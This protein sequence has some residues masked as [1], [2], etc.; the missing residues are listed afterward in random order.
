[1]RNKPKMTRL[2]LD[3]R[4]KGRVIE[5]FSTNSF[6]Y[7]MHSFNEWGIKA[8][9]GYGYSHSFSGILRDAEAR[10]QIRIDSESMG[11]TTQDEMCASYS[12]RPEAHEY[13][14]KTTRE[15]CGFCRMEIL[16]AGINQDRNFRTVLRGLNGAEQVI[17][18]FQ[19]GK[20][21]LRR[22]TSEAALKLLLQAS[23]LEY[24]YLRGFY[25]PSGGVT[26]Q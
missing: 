24:T 16:P 8:W 19:W 9:G 23:D 20:R 13:Y 3:P 15:T 22:N 1:M 4:Y 25:L 11:T 26:G 17:C 6:R 7:G 21:R 18:H 10:G 14:N 2:L 5:V 12:W